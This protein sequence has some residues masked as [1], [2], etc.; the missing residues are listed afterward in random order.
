MDDSWF[1]EEVRK[2]DKEWEETMRRRDQEI[3]EHSQFL[4]NMKILGFVLFGVAVVVNL[5]I[6]FRIFVLKQP[7]PWYCVNRELPY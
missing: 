7:V 5:F 6:L 2:Q 4:D 3:E 1:D